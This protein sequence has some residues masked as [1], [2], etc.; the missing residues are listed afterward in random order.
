MKNYEERFVEDL[1]MRYRNANATRRERYWKV[2]CLECG[3]TAEVVAATFKHANA[4]VCKICSSRELLTTHGQR[5]TRLYK[6]WLGARDRCRNPKHK[7]YVDYG[8]RGINFDTLWDDFTTF[9]DWADSN[10]YAEDK[11]LDRQDND[12][13]YS[14]SNCRWVSSTAQAR[15]RRK[16]SSKKTSSIHKG[17]S[18]SGDRFVARITI[19]YKTHN[20]GTYSTQEYA[21]EAYNQYILT[22]NLEDF[23]LN[24]IKEV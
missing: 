21:A 8:G 20:L 22:N 19:D 7:R 4:R 13:G 2:K 16:I 6:I 12:K 18:K 5:Y 3:T 24:D 17:V 10:G 14:V 9:K 23:I 15:N 11:S 1:G